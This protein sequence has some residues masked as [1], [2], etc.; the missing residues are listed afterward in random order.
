MSHAK[1]KKRK[2][3]RI[4]RKL[5]EKSASVIKKKRHKDATK[6]RNRKSQTQKR[7]NGVSTE[8]INGRPAPHYTL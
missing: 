6:L 2:S 5:V 4:S 7:E 1:D 8:K 3:E